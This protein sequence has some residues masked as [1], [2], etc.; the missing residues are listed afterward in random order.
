MTHILK[1]WNE[2]KSSAHPI[3]Y[4]LTTAKIVSLKVYYIELKQYLL[5]FLVYSKYDSL[6]I[7]TFL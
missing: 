2:N 3:N 1:R 7:V 6:Y 4:V 5:S